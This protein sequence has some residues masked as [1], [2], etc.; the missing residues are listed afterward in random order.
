[1][2]VTIV[3]DAIDFAKNVVGSRSVRTAALGYEPLVAVG[4]SATGRDFQ[5]TA[6]SDS[7]PWPAAR[8]VRESVSWHF[9]VLTLAARCSLCDGPPIGRLVGGV[10]ARPGRV[11]TAASLQRR[12]RWRRCPPLLVPRGGCDASGSGAGRAGP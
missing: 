2:S 10:R 3:R 6:A 11:S 9:L 1:M 5:F 4:A 8:T 12:R 7:W